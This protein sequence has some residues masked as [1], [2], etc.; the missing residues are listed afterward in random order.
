MRN[1]Q[2]YNPTLAWMQ[3]FAETGDKALEKLFT[4]SSNFLLKFGKNNALNKALLFPYIETFQDMM[5]HNPAVVLE[6]ITEILR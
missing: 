6:L 3:L 5:N 2:A 1:L 4:G